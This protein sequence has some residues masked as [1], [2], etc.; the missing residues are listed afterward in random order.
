M[1]LPNPVIFMSFI[2]FTF[3]DISLRA[4]SRGN[5]VAIPHLFTP[6]QINQT[7]TLH[8]EY[9]RNVTPEAADMSRLIWDAQLAE[10]AT[11]YSRGCPTYTSG[12]NANGGNKYLWIG[13]NMYMTSNIALDED[14]IPKMIK[15]WYD[16]R[17]YYKDSLCVP[18]KQCGHY[19][20]VVWAISYQIGCG[21]T[22][23]GELYVADKMRKMVTVVVC[24]YVPGGNFSP[25][26]YKE[27]KACSKCLIGQDCVDSMCEVTNPLNFTTK[28]PIN[29]GFIYVNLD[30]VPH[31]NPPSDRITAVLR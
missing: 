12:E 23:C 9:R 18:R 2:Q 20:Q 28:K 24:N 6:S 11:E 29:G 3:G 25:L 16:E 8:N 5:N 17:Q 1:L 4:Q 7:V 30:L 21:M 26:P 10:I 22:T 15:T 27:G 13:E 31:T 19:T 14:Y